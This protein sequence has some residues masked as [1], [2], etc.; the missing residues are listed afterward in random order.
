MRTLS[1]PFL[2]RQL[3]LWL[4]LAS[5]VIVVILCLSGTL[6]ALQAPIEAWVNR[7]VS[8]VSP[9]GEPLPLETL[10]P[11]VQAATGKT[12]SALEVPRNEHE[13]LRL[14][15]GRKVTYVHPSTGEVLGGVNQ[16]VAEA[17]MGV[18]RLHRWLL[19]DTEIGRP[20]TGAATVVFV[21][22]LV[23]GLFLWWPK[24]LSRLKAALTI[25]TRPNWS[26]L[27]RDLHAVLGLYALVPLFIMGG[28][29][30]YWSYNDAFK[31]TA[32]LLLDGRPAPAKPEERRPEAK[33][34]VPP[35]SRLPYAVLLQQTHE[36]FPYPGAVRITF[37]ESPDRPV[38]I[39]KTHSPTAISVPYVDRLKADVRTGEVRAR[40]PFSSK[41]RAEQ[42]LSLIKA[43]HTG[44]VGGGLTLVLYLLACLIGTSLPISGALHWLNKLR[45]RRRAAELRL[46]AQET[47]AKAP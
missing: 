42:F 28:S 36:A 32:H 1:L 16:P 22:T 41:T 14:Y 2:L 24:S 8:T 39:A 35:F 5:S 30:L 34:D 40:E 4:G 33:P 44:T 15:Q 21:V 25:R 12:F 3:H 7:G 18:F 27:N 19:F 13:A 17:F 37:P 47:A 23:S 31:Q 9:S 26:V 6:L 38:L 46:G 11:K 29:G 43:I 10:V 45:G 20:I